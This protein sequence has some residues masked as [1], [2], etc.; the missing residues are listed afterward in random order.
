MTLFHSPI[1]AFIHSFTHSSREPSGTWIARG[2]AEPSPQTLVQQVMA[3]R[4]LLI[5]S[6]RKSSSLGPFFGGTNKNNYFWAYQ[7]SM[8]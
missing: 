3:R 8:F 2:P 6:R 4:A 5:G 1:R 7:I